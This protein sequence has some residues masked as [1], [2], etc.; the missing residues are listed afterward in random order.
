[1]FSDC[2][3]GGQSSAG[4]R[5]WKSARKSASGYPPPGDVGSHNLTAGLLNELTIAPMR[6]AAAIRRAYAARLKQV[7]P[8]EW[9]VFRA[10]LKGDCVHFKGRFWPAMVDTEGK[11]PDASLGLIP[12]RG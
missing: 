12:N 9:H 1:M 10:C 3:G 2:Q 5:R 11:R 4:N 6:D 8:N 7:Q